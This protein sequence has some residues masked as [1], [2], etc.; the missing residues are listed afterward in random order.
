MTGPYYSLSANVHFLRERGFSMK[1]SELLKKL[2]EGKVLSLEM[3]EL[4]KEEIY[5]VSGGLGS[6]GGESSS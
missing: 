5:I 1:M 3:R 4:S 2:N 6:C